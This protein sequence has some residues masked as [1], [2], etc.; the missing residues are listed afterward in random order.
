MV[1]LMDSLSLVQNVQSTTLI[2]EK[3]LRVNIASIQESIG[4][5]EVSLE[6]IPHAKQLADILTKNGVDP[7]I[8]LS[9][10]GGRAD[11]TVQRHDIQA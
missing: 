6:W 5:E 3:R 2:S 7:S 1:A 10:L 4:K 11:R 9:A 8:L